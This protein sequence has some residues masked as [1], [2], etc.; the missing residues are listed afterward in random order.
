M[1]PQDIP[2]A[3][4]RHI[5]KK[6]VVLRK[7]QGPGTHTV[8]EYACPQPVLLRQ[9]TLLLSVESF[10]FI[11]PRDYMCRVVELMLRIALETAYMHHLA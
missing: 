9:D 8:I 6:N 10:Y 7:K 2:C 5:C 3:T 4:Q 1:I 11:I